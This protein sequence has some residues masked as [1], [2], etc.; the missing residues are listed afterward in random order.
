MRL[1]KEG[2]GENAASW[3][4]VEG[5]Q[6]FFAFSLAIFVLATVL[7]FIPSDS[8]SGVCEIIDFITA[9]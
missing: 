4:E 2:R 3:R 7:S 6:L 1:F 9:S 8:E 5:E